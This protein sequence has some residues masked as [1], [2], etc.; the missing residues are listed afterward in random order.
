M[1]APPRQAH[2]TASKLAQLLG[3]VLVHHAPHTAR[4]NAET[5]T[6]A[7]NEWLEGLE[8][9]TSTLIA[10]VLQGLLDRSDPP[11]EIRALIEEAISPTA[12]FGS[13]LQ[14]IFLWGI[15][16]N[17]IGSSL[18]P[19]LVAV[20]NQLNTSAV[21]A[22]IAVPVDASTIATA[23]GRGLNLGDPPTVTV[24][25]WAYTEAAKQGVSKDDIDLQ[26]SLI[27]LPPALQELFELYRR[28]DI[29]LDDVKQGLREGDF[30]DDWIERTL[31]LAHA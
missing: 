8:A 5:S 12:Q 19:F 27:G 17:I 16:S 18:Q 23:A 25:D 2:Q 31:G 22:G 26:A 29:N 10:P 13:T 1:P 21:A 3:E 9:H 14:Q 11:A 30:R 7:V 20:T 28:G 15:V 4:I 24:P 6:R